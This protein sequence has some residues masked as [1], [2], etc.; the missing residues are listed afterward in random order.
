VV[1]GANE[2]AVTAFLQGKI[3]F[4][5]IVA[6][7]SETAAAVGKAAAPA[8]LEEAEEIDRIARRLASEITHRLSRVAVAN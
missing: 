7:I 6:V 1:N 8:T 3:S 5:E 4:P 2:I